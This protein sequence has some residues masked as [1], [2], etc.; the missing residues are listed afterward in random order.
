MKQNNSLFFKI[1]SSRLFSVVFFILIIYLSVGVYSSIRERLKVKKE[2]SNLQKE[3]SN[4]HNENSELT[5]LIEYFESDEYV[6]NS[7]R[8]KLGYKKP[9]EKI[10][11]FTDDNDIQ[12]ETV[13]K[14]KPE[15]KANRKLWWDY[16]FNLKT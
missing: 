16:F 4:L 9:G 12:E 13:Y 5:G 7:S 2:I 6:E 14:N 15:K 8:E 10:I 3:I 1:L 11:V